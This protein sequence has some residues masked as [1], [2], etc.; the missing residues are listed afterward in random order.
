MKNLIFILCFLS[1]FSCKKSQENISKP[2]SNIAVL[3]KQWQG[4]LLISDLSFINSIDASCKLNTPFFDRSEKQINDDNSKCALS[5]IKFDYE[6]LN[7]LKNKTSIGKINPQTELFLKATKPQNDENADI[8][9][10]ATLY[11]EVNKKTT[12]SIVIYHT[13]NFS[14]ALTAKERSYYINN[15]N[16][17]LLDI[18][19]DESGSSVEKWSKNKINS[20]GKIILET[21]KLFSS[22]ASNNSE[23][24]KDDTWKG[25][26]YFEAS[27]RDEAKTIFE[28]NINSLD[29]ISINVTEDGT[30]TNYSHQKAEKIDSEK[31]KIAYDSSSDDMGTIFIEKSDRQYFISGNPIYFIN[32]GNNKMP[33]KKIK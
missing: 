8:Y 26:Y 28:I 21:H 9:N 7:S 17:Y 30:K 20:S 11:V 27:N 23:K 18:V 25:M 15:E 3:D 13:V 24:T 4:D 2:I 32:P 14:E 31:I 29:D 6:K 33:L 5:K 10:Q 19:E 12:D 22:I 16:I 1:I